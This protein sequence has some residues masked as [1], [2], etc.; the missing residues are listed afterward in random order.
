M[1]QKGEAPPPGFVTVERTRTGGK[2]DLN[3]GTGGVQQFLCYRCDPPD[4]SAPITALAVVFPDQGEFVPPR[5]YR[6]DRAAR[7]VVDWLYAPVDSN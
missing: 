3:H 5:A 4:R 1:L 2:A 7:K 6:G